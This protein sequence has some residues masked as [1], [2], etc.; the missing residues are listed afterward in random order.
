M[1]TWFDYTS[2][3]GRSMITKEQWQDIETRLKGMF[4]SISFQLGTDKITVQRGFVSEGRSELAVYL[5]GWINGKWS[6]KPED[7]DYNPL[8]EKFW[9]RKER[10][11]Y[12]PKEKR[13]IIKGFGK[14][15]AIKTFPNLD[16]KMVYYSTCWPRAKTLVNQF[17]KIKELELA[18]GEPG[19]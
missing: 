19:T 16:K 14:K 8:I 10:S 1:D 12:P 4:A 6:C 13:I 9:H 3:K 7:K 2:R 18:K 15:G 5:N 17:K 11:F